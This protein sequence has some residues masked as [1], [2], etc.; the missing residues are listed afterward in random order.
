MLA[1]CQS[2]FDARAIPNLEFSV[3]YAHIVNQYL[4][5]SI[6]MI[7]FETF[8]L[9]ALNSCFTSDDFPQKHSIIIDISLSA[10][11]ILVC[12]LL[13]ILPV[14]ILHIHYQIIFTK[15]VFVS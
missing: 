3:T 5:N 12:T 15:F 11:P 4:S 8:P 9:E 1:L 14:P 2:T 6:L 10:V 7:I 13:S